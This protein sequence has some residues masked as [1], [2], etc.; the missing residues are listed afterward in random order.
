MYVLEIEHPVR[1]YD[2]WK[3]TFDS[4][5]IGRKRSGV[6]RYQIL[7]PVGD[8]LYVLIRLEFDSAKEAE[9]TLAALRQVWGRVQGTLIESPQARIVETIETKEL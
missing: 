7:R 1:D 6:R 9:A 8:P 5:P 4:D 3:K 2:A